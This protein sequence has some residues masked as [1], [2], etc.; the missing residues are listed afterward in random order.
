MMPRELLFVGGNGHCAARLQPARDALA[1]LEVAVPF[2]LRE[3]ECPGFDGRPR[4]R[5]IEVLVDA[6]RL[7]VGGARE[8]TLVYATG[9]GA[10]LALA[11]RAAAGG[12]AAPLLLQAPVLWGLERRLMPRLMRRAPVRALARRLFRRPWFQRR[13]WRRIVALPWTDPARPAFFEGYERCAAFA[14]LFAWLGPAFLRRLEEDLRARPAALADVEV[15]WG[16]RDAVVSP[17]E[18][19]P[20]AERLGA[21]WPLRVFP[22]WGHYPMLDDPA[23]WVRA[24]AGALEAQPPLTGGMNTTSSPAASGASNRS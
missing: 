2:A 22:E 21:R 5:S 13:L 11:A 1:A 8:G 6:V 15:W 16:G 9:V 24:V 12:A 17:D 14:D 18:I 20:A 19:E 10:L 3:V 7:Q 23:G 4:A